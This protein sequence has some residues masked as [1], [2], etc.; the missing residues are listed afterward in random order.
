MSR[1]VVAG[2]VVGGVA[3]ILFLAFC[4]YTGFYKKKKK[5]KGS[6][7]PEATEQHHGNSLG[8]MN[9]CNYLFTVESSIAD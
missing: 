7:L 1:G 4:L 2:T 5:G 9:K 6:L 3:G 8:L